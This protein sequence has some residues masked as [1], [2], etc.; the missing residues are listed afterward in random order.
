MKRLIAIF[1]AAVVLAFPGITS[2][3]NDY[4]QSEAVILLVEYQLLD[5]GYDPGAI[6]G[7]FDDAARS[8]VLSFEK[9]EGLPQDGFIT[10]NL[11][12]RM[13][14][15]LSIRKTEDDAVAAR[16]DAGPLWIV[17]IDPDGT[18][19]RGVKRGS[20]ADEFLRLRAGDVILKFDGKAVS[21][22]DQLVELFMTAYNNVNVPVT[23]VVK[24]G[25]ADVELS[26][27]LG[28]FYE[29]GGM[30]M[31]DEGPVQ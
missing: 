17:G 28:H 10:D 9:A 2:A 11:L 24:R 27:E 21:D 6:D 15:L 19:V 13:D 22:L 30:P 3:Q 26:G 5:L 14:V 7:V 25:D 31:P 29:D 20:I 8:A 12:N 1:V 4:M 16:A 18:T 23:L